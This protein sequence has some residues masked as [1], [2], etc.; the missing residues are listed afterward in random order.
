MRRCA[1]RDALLLDVKVFLASG[2]CGR[3]ASSTSVATAKVE[4][5]G[6]VMHRRLQFLLCFTIV[7]APE[8]FQPQ[9]YYDSKGI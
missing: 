7:L 4:V 1:K 2:H 6:V 9:S 5:S 3:Q 8:I